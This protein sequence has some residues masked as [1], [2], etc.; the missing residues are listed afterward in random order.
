MTTIT[1]RPNC[2][3]G[4]A[5]LTFLVVSD[6][7]TS[8]FIAVDCGTQ[9]RPISP[10]TARRSLMS[11]GAMMLHRSHRALLSAQLWMTHAS[12]LSLHALPIWL[13][14]LFRQA[15]MRPPR[16]DTGAILQIFPPY[17][18][19]ISRQQEPLRKM[20]LRPRLRQGK[21]WSSSN[22]HR[23]DRQFWVV[24]IHR[25]TPMTT[26]QVGYNFRR[27]AH[28]DRHL[29]HQQ[30]QQAA[31]QPARLAA[32]GE[33]RRR[34]PAGAE[35]DRRANF[36]AAALAKAGYGAVW[37]G[38]KTWN[39]VAIL[40]RGAEPV[41]T[42]DALPGDPADAQSRYIEAAVD[43]VLVG[44]ALPAERQSAAG[45]EIRLQA[46]LVRAA[47]SRTRRSCWRRTCRSC[48]PATTTSCRP[49]LDIYPTQS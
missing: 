12:M 44:C 43:G 19:S 45:P 18:R 32:R 24:S 25:G 5:L 28:E 34:L 4:A 6:F 37:R 7:L 35:G 10:T 41:L 49:T 1:I 16:H 46:R 42:R 26:V 47:A 14:Y 27:S 21:T 30:R 38:Q 17:R 8:G 40:A 48:W 39:G 22:L 31:G 2:R 36:R 3:Y 13:L 33:A 9:R 29:Q 15:T 20:R 11:L 23:V